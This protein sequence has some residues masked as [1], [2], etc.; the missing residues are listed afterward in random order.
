[1][2]ARIA[3]SPTTSKSGPGASAAPEATDSLLRTS[4]L[5]TEPSVTA[6]VLPSEGTDSATRATS[7]GTAM[8][9]D[10]A[11]DNTD[12]GDVDASLA[13]ADVAES[14]RKAAAPRA[15]VAATANRRRFIMNPPRSV[16]FGR[17]CKQHRFGRCCARDAD[18]GGTRE[19]TSLAT[20]S[21]LLPTI[22][23]TAFV[24]Q[25]EDRPPVLGTPPRFVRNAHR[26][27]EVRRS[28]RTMDA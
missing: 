27:A 28:G 3:P 26:G 4:L 25:Y 6:G 8:E 21:P 23:G 13:R 2:D 10:T 11:T 5:C 18:S 16:R 15:T 14:P 9:P 20:L 19:V 17:A 12:A 22:T 1:M 24:G 7:G